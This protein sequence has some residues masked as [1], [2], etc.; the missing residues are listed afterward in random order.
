MADLSRI[1]ALG[2]STQSQGLSWTD[3][4]ENFSETT[5]MDQVTMPAMLK[6]KLSKILV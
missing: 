3:F 6:G 4:G 1:L 5:F 2:A